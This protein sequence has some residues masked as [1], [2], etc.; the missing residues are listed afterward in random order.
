M[1][2]GIP[3]AKSP[4]PGFDHQKI[5]GRIHFQLENLLKNCKK[6]QAILPIDRRLDT[7]TDDNVIQPDNMIYC[8][9]V[10][11]SFITDSPSLIFEIISP[12]SV[13]KDRVIK[14][15]IYETQGVKYYVIIDPE[16]K[17]ADVFELKENK[18]V[19]IAETKND[20]LNFELDDDCKIDFN[21][22]EIWS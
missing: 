8:K 17:I 18:Y 13:L 1:I 4:D 12:S 10:K 11:K 20:T 9:E 14:Y 2:H 15:K 5:S 3:Y 22:S 7:E 21:F 16:S 6:C 19:K